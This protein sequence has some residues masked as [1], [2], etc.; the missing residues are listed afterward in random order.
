MQRTETKRRLDRTRYPNPI[1]QGSG[2]TL[3]NPP[4]TETKGDQYDGVRPGFGEER[5]KTGRV[6]A[7]SQDVSSTAV[8]TGGRAALGLDGAKTKPRTAEEPKR[9]WR[10]KNNEAHARAIDAIF[11]LGGAAPKSL[12]TRWKPLLEITTAGDVARVKALF[13]Q[14]DPEHADEH[15]VR[16]WNAVLDAKKS[17]P[18]HVKALLEKVPDDWAEKS[19]PYEL[20]VDSFGT[21]E[22]QSTATFDETRKMFPYLEW[23][24]VNTLSL[25]PVF[26]SPGWDGGYD[27]SKFTPAESLGG[28]AAYEEAVQDGLERG[29]YTIW[30]LVINHVSIQHPWYE[31]LIAGDESMLDRFVVYDGVEIVSEEERNGDKWIKYR[32][33]D[34]TDE[35]QLLIFPDTV[36]H[37]LAKVEVNGREHQLFRTFNPFQF[38][39]NPKNPDVMEW[40]CQI[41]GNHLN[42]GT[43]GIRLDA[44]RHVMKRKGV[45][46]HDLEE[47]HILQEILKHFVKHVSPKAIIVPEVV[48]GTEQ[49]SQYFGEPAEI[50]GVKTTSEADAMYDFDRRGVLQHALY[51]QKSAPFWNEIHGYPEAPEGTVKYLPLGTHD[52]V[53]VG[54]IPWQEDWPYIRDYAAERGCLPFKQGMSVTGRNADLLDNDPRRIANSFFVQGVFFPGCNP[55][56]YAGDEI[57]W[58]NDWDYARSTHEQQFHAL[59]EEAG[60]DVTEER[61]FDARWIHRGPIPAAAFEKARASQY[62]PLEMVKRLNELRGERRALRT[63]GIHD[64]EN[65]NDAVISAVRFAENEAP[66]L[67]L[68]NLSF[69]GKTIR[70]PLE[71]LCRKMN[72]PED[73]AVEQL[74]LV[75]LLG[76]GPAGPGARVPLHVHDGAV[77]MQL[78]PYDQRLFEL[79]VRD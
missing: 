73:A 79:R 49:A 4:Q 47:T 75:D 34:G 57:G 32:W 33:P 66:I 45:P 67:A 53:F 17:Q 12:R 11:G 60:L 72:V 14:F 48:A 62:A 63:G 50:A 29:L 22:G 6:R 15:V 38:D 3:E 7:S 69:E 74:E 77:V 16:F 37:H 24:G 43:L 55:T 56:I 21:N 59:R 5:P 9:L 51:F 20:Y 40:I 46:A 42:V 30:D 78:E 65:G 13:E 54:F 64:V 28:A 39:I 58:R 18:A 76:K 27:I 36:D 41:V 19:A 8:L 61:T 71:D 31:A 26:E 23:L 70:I 44:L 10:G 68:S 25:R 35:E 1:G 52:E 2:R